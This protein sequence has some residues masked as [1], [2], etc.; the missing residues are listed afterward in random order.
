LYAFFVTKIELKLSKRVEASFFSTMMALA[1]LSGFP[2][3][4]TAFDEAKVGNKG[5]RPIDEAAGGEGNAEIRFD[6]FLHC[7][8]APL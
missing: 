4:M 5:P 1:L 7:A 2:D 6:S 8:P 3:P